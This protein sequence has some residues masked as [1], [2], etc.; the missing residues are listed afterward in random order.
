MTTSVP[1]RE[2]VFR[3]TT[4]GPTLLAGRC[5]HCDH[6]A[7]PAAEHCPNCRAGDQETVELGAEGELLCATVVHMGNQHFP[8]GYTVGYVTMPHGVRV[9]SQLA[10]V[11]EELPAPGTPMTI[12]IVP[13]WHADD[14]DVVA[15]RFVPAGGK[16][17]SDA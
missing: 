14:H 13:M 10:N 6:T 9:F 15:Y 3:E 11:G 1:L 2:G 5:P 16:G 4:A 17:T 8:P 12:E 7:F